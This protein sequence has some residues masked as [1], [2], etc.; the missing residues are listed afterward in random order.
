MNQTLMEKEILETAAVVAAHAERADIAAFGA[1]LKNNPPKMLLTIGRGTSDHAAEYLSYWLMRYSGIPAASIPLSLNTVYQT[2]WHAKDA[3]AL[4]ISQ[5]GGSQDVVESVNN[6]QHHGIPTITLVNAV[7]S[8]LSE[9]SKQTLPLQAGEEISVAATKSF[10]AS[11]SIG[12]RA[13]NALFADSSLEKA[14]TTLPEKIH[15]AENLDWSKAIEA[16]K[17]LDRLYIVGRGAGLPIAKEAALKCKE[18]SLL[19]GEAF[20]GAEVKHGPMA[21]INPRQ[22]VLFL[23]PPDE[24][25]AGLVETAQQ[26]RAMG[27][28]VLL[29]ADERVASRDL[30]LIDAGHP[31]LQGITTIQTFYRMAEKLSA[32]RG[33]NTDNPPNLNKVTSTR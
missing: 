12:L 15:A 7:P 20:S 27:A 1:A 3:L 6:L 16:L 30:P 33:I 26:F 31:A 14:L 24:M 22:T 11:L 4:A 28:N 5:S 19:Q 13:F 29:A 25:Q 2:Q 8:P 17:G 18:T 10:I 21:L 23:A 9:V 32:A